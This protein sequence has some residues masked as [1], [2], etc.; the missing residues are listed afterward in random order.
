MELRLPAVHWTTD[1]YLTVGSWKKKK[2]QQRGVVGV[3]Q[4]DV[5]GQFYF[6]IYST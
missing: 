3:R 5:A 6:R 1:K 2:K 4:M